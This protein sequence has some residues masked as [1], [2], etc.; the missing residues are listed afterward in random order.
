MINPRSILWNG[1]KMMRYIPSIP[2]RSPV[3]AAAVPQCPPSNL[4][5]LSGL[6]GQARLL[7]PTGP[8]AA[9]ADPVPPT[10][11]EQLL[12]ATAFKLLADLEGL[13]EASRRPQLAVERLVYPLSCWRAVWD[14]RHWLQP[15][16][17][18]EGRWWLALRIVE[19]WSSDRGR[20]LVIR[21]QQKGAA[22]RLLL[23]TLC[24]V[25]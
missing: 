2:A 23:V 24:S 11:W 21:S 1:T 6:A 7:S 9:L 8:T 12:T 18:K 10:Q 16:G 17:C 13:Q 22:G 20:F 15:I 5:S 19:K 4:D 14:G 3:A 25:K